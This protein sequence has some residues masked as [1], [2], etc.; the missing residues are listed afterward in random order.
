MIAPILEKM[1]KE[2]PEIE[3]F[4]VDVDDASEVSNACGIECMPTFHF[5]K[6][7]EKVDE[8]IGADPDELKKMVAKLK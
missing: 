3:F 7:G 6:G 1:A 5:Y 4:K 8:L 2:N